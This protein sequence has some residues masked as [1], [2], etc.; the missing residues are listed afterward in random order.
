MTAAPTVGFY[1][2]D[3]GHAHNEV[4]LPWGE[5]EE[6]LRLARQQ[7]VALLAAPEWHLRAVNHPAA[8]VLLR[9][10]EPY[11]GLRYLATLGDDARGRM[12]VYEIPRPPGA[13]AA[14]P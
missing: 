4:T 5:A 10:R 3:A 11:P 13:A 8:A 2:Y 1:F 6:I 9:P 14:T 12:F 7:D